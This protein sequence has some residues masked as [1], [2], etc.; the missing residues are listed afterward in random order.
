MKSQ[1]CLD[2]LN[3]ILKLLFYLYIFIRL[4]WLFMINFIYWVKIIFLKLIIFK[5]NLT[6]IL[7][8]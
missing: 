7:L 6:H 8:K 3:N 2:N 5:K 4:L 1:I